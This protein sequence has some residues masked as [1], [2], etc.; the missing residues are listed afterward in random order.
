MGVPP[1]HHLQLSESERVCACGPDLRSHFCESH[2]RIPP[3]FISR[4]LYVPWLGAC[5]W[6]SWGN[7]FCPPSENRGRYISIRK[8]R[9]RKSRCV[10]ETHLPALWALRWVLNLTVWRRVIVAVSGYVYRIGLETGWF[11]LV[12]TDRQVVDWLTTCS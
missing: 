4:V 9:P 12:S 5:A 6:C 1:R 8:S 2:S 11:D 7:C 3:S 10:F